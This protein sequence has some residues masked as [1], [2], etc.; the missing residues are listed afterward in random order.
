MK[1]IK[2][3]KNR[4]WI[5]LHGVTGEERSL[6]RLLSAHGFRFEPRGR[7]WWGE[8]S[9]VNRE[10]LSGIVNKSDDEQVEEVEETETMKRIDANEETQALDITALLEKIAKLEAQIEQQKAPKSNETP[11]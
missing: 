10:L 6:H 11:Y 5:Q 3:T 8:N 2:Y 9:K 7:H 4:R 1:S